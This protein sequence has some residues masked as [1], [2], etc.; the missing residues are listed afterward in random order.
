MSLKPVDWNVVI[1]GRWNASILTP[2]RIAEK[3]FL[4]EPQEEESI[5]RLPIMVPLDGISP[6]QVRDPEENITVL[7][8]LNRLIIRTNEPTYTSLKLAMQAGKNAIEWLPET[9]FNGAGFNIRYRTPEHPTQLTRITVNNQIDN[10]L[11]DLDF[12]IDSRTSTRSIK[13]LGYILNITITDTSKGMEILCNFHCG[14]G[15]KEDLIQWL[16]TPVSEVEKIVS[17][18]LN[19]QEVEIMEV[20]HDDSE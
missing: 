6:Y 3:I 20:E 9:P 5:L 18:I 10:S 17:D 11:S 15:K 19:S 8:D 16:T 4:I 14:S 1:V 12:V 13:C 2:G 7:L